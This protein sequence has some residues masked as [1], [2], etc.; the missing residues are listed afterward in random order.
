VAF[1][2][3]ILLGWM[4]FDFQTHASQLT[5][6]SEFSTIYLLLWCGLAGVSACAILLWFRASSA[7]SRRQSTSGRVMKV[8]GIAVGIL[9]A[10]ALL[11]FGMLYGDAR[12]VFVEV[13]KY[14]N[15]KFSF[16]SDHQL[17]RVEGDI[18][19]GF[20]DALV[21]AIERYPGMK[22]MQIE[23]GG[24]LIDEALSAAATIEARGIPVFVEYSCH[25]ACILIFAAAKER[26]ATKSAVLGFHATYPV[27]QNRYAKFVTVDAKSQSYDFL[28]RRGIPM[29]IL[30]KSL[31]FGPDEIL[32]V[33][34]SELNEVGFRIE[35][36][37]N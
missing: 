10:V 30:D 19:P 15:Y 12:D 5:T 9:Y 17:L 11:F 31:Q 33:S 27:T 16:L 25:S 3:S 23:S 35:L 26:W 2:A 13:Q 4:L 21:E 18:G 8:I 29:E 14:R 36:L 1:G 22:W 32:P 37:P 24:G 20:A 6:L 34:A 28:L 7:P